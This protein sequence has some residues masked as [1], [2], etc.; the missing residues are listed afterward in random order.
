MDGGNQGSNQGSKEQHSPSLDHPY[1]RFAK[2]FC[3]AAK[4]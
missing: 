2:K 3:C 1:F 4:G